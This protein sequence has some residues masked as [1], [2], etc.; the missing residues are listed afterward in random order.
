MDVLTTAKGQAGLPR[1]FAMAFETAG[2]P[3]EG[4]LDFVLPDG[5]RFR[6]EGKAPGIAAE[7]RVVN[8]DLF[9]RLV[10]EG[11]LGGE[12]KLRVRMVLTAD[13][14]DLRHQVDGEIDLG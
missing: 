1:Y 10:R 4:R 8:P 6:V 14:T 13:G 5:R 9:A 2:K 12:G 11:D 3:G 7:V